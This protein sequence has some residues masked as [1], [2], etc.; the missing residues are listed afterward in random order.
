M[1]PFFI[2]NPTSGVGK[3]KELWKKLIPRIQSEL[4]SFESVFTQSATDATRQARLALKNGFRWIIAVGG[5]GTLHEVLNGF[6]EKEKMLYPDARL[7]ILPVGSGDD[8][9]RSIGWGSDPFEAIEKLKKGKT[10]AIDVGKVSYLNHAG[11][12]ESRFFLNIADFGLGGKVMQ[13]VNASSKILGAKLTYLFHGI[14]SLITFRPASALLETSEKNYHFQNLVIGIVANG[15]YF[16]SGL[17]VAPEASL[18]D[19]LFDVIIV[20]KLEV[21]DLVKLLPQLYRGEVIEH[22]S[23]TR[24]RTNQLSVESHS[25]EPVWLETDGEQPGRLPASFEII[26]QSLNFCV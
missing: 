16:G 6:F 24:F 17:G 12:R 8:F 18:E 19:G 25:S 15:R 23:I 22:P 20:E 4:G 21:L 9:K 14:T 26:P 5:D 3:A 13:E 2:I 7:G 11:K 10:I 1:I